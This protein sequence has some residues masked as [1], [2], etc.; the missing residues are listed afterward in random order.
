MTLNMRQSFK[1]IPK[2]EG[3]IMAIYYVLSDGQSKEILRC[4]FPN[5]HQIGDNIKVAESIIPILT[6]R[7]RRSL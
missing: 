2:F 5:D 1:L 7:I 3:N 4:I 6:K